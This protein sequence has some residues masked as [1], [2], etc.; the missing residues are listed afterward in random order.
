MKEG[1]CIL[2]MWEHV[3]EGMCMLQMWECTFEGRYVYVTDVET[4]EER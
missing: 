1:M 2:Q 3:K 4:Y